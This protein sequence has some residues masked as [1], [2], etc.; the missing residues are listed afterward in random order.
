MRRPPF[1]ILYED[2]DIV[3]IDKPAGL[4]TTHTRLPGRAAR[5]AQPTAENFLTD[6]LRKGQAKSRLRVWLVHRLDRETS[7][8]LMFAK[9]SELAETIRDNWNALTE[10]QYRARVE[11]ELTEAEG[12]FESY[13]RDDPRTLKVSSVDDP[14][15]GKAARTDWRRLAV[16]GGTT[17]VDV[18][19]R[20]GRKNQIRVHF[21]E[22]GHP[23]VGDVKYGASKADRLYLHACELR[24]RHPVTGRVWHWRSPAPFA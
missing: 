9:S 1:P 2:R 16:A 21:S 7:G 5:A 20:T 6:F 19:L 11:G 23:V 14:A 15:C 10:K 13:L 8:V 24:F 4:L 3:V 17:L 22:A 18:T 12:R